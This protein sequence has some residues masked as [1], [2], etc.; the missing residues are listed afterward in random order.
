MLLS[1]SNTPRAESGSK[2]DQRGHGIQVLKRKC[3]LI[4]LESASIRAFRST[5]GAAPGSS[6][7]ACCSKSSEAP[8]PTSA[9]ADDHQ[10][11]HQSHLA[12][13]AYKPLRL[14]RQHQATPPQLQARH[15]ASG[16]IFPGQ[17]AFPRRIVA[18]GIFKNVNGPEVPEIF[19]VGNRLPDQSSEKPRRGRRRHRQPLM[20]DQR[21]NRDDRATDR[22]PPRARRA[23][24]RNALPG[25]IRKGKRPTHKPQRHPRISDG[26]MNSMSFS[27]WSGSR[28]S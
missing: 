25:Q 10:H 27:F 24:H 4:W 26:V 23:I 3:G 8:P 21:R 22:P 11:S 28:S 14:G 2:P 18:F 12:S 9:V 15:A 17:S 19:F 5:A 13:M 7:R 1:C 20:R 16:A 6:R